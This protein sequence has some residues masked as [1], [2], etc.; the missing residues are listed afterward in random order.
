MRRDQRVNF[1]Y[2][3]QRGGPGGPIKIGL[4]TDPARRL[5]ALATGSAEPLALL[6][7]LA[8]DHEA[9]LHLRL[10]AH[11]MQGEWFA[12]VP[13]VLAE[14]PAAKPLPVATSVRSS[15]PKGRWVPVRSPDPVGS[16][17]HDL[18]RQVVGCGLGAR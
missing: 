3:I 17:A 16:L 14:V 4:S 8:G 6:G 5:R 7:V 1:T 11:R 15:R 9:V 13:A 10:K 18:M 2:F 12:P